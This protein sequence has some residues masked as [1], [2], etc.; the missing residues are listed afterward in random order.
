MDKKV[1]NEIQIGR[2]SFGKGKPLGFILGPC[3]IESYDQLFDIGSFL[4]ENSPYPFILKG[5]FDKAN[6]SSISS[7]RGPGIEKGMEYLA[8]IKSALDLA[9]T[10]D[11]HLPEHA[12][13]VGEVCDLIQIPAFLARQTDLVVSAAKTMVPIHVKKGQFM[14]PYDMEHVA[15]KILSTGNTQ[16]IFTERGST[17]G[18]KNLVNDFRSFPIMEKYCSAVCYDVTHS[19]Q[20]PG[21][22]QESG[23]ERA[24]MEPLAKAA[25]VCGAD[26]IFLETHKNPAEAKSDKAT[27]WP[28][29]KTPALLK[30]LYELRM[31]LQEE[32]MA[33]A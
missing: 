22:G 15:K 4:K 5:S 16:I 8:R 17:F 26:I 30:K 33:N 9:V 28:L 23:G 6:R 25:V 19:G 29:E 12:E 14:S 31:Y 27:Q 2:Q 7:Y 18:Y 10:T 32:R 21:Q 20:L 24:F 3:V 13:M 1:S 11:I